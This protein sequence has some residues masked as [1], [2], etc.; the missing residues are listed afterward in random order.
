MRVTNTPG[1]SAALPLQGWP[2][3]GHAYNLSK[4]TNFHEA[5]LND[6]ICPLTWLPFLLPSD[7][8]FSLSFRLLL[9]RLTCNTT[10]I[11]FQEQED[12]FHQVFAKY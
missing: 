6:Y 5:Q 3:L 1:V 7:P 8:P 2:S 11:E 10:H 12:L 9:L 4:H